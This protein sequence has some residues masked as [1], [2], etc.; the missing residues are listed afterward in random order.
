MNMHATTKNTWFLKTKIHKISIC[1]NRF[2]KVNNLFDDKGKQ[3]KNSKRWMNAERKENYKKVCRKI[4]RKGKV[5][6]GEGQGK[7]GY[8]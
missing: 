3:V 4:I 6:F 5:P 7:P 1:L 2:L 8:N